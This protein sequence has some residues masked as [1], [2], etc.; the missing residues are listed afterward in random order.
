MRCLPVEIFRRYQMTLAG[1]INKHGTAV[2]AKRWKV[3]QRIVQ[4]WLIGKHRPQT[5]IADRIAKL[6]DLTRRDIYA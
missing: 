4:M 6:G 5:K 3:S 1:Y 2:C